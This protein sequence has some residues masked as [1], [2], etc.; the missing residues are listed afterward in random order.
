MENHETQASD[1][2]PNNVVPFREDQVRQRVGRALL[3]WV[4]STEVR[5]LFY[6][7]AVTVPSTADSFWEMWLNR[8]TGTGIEPVALGGVVEPLPARL[9]SCEAAIRAT[10][11][12]KTMYEPL[13]AQFVSVSVDNLVTPQWWLDAGHVEELLDDLPAEDDLEGLFRFCFAQGSV[14]PPLLL[15]TNGAVLTSRKRGLGMI[16]PLRV[17]SVAVDKIT[18]EFDALPRP[19]WLWLSIVPENGS[20]L[21]LNGVHHVATLQRARRHL[22][23]ALIRQG[24]L[25]ASMNFQEPAIFKPERLLCPRP[26]LV[27]DFYD[28]QLADEVCIRAVDQFMRFGV[29]NPPE[30]GF[31]PQAAT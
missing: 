30:I 25:Q 19:N 6:A 13:G 11:Q 31:V 9:A 22:A 12:F 27:R 14:Q 29:Q 2:A 8:R 5:P 17:A 21:V 28:D 23:F 10:D 26:P 1:E 3:H 16:S 24:P 15:G 18:F 7:S 20:I 4:N